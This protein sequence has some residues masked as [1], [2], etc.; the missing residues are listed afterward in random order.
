MDD[1]NKKGFS[2]LF[3]SLSQLI[4][5]A[6]E[7]KGR[8]TIQQEGEIDLGNIKDGMKAMYGFRL[9][10]LSGGIP[11]VET[12]G[13]VKNTPE[14]PKVAEERE[15]LTDIFD[16]ADLIKVYVEMPGVEA[17]DVSVKLSGD[18]LEISAKNALRNYRK[19]LLLPTAVVQ[20]SLSQQF[21]NGMLEIQLTKSEASS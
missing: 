4:D 15:P 16:E 20:D 3:D 11:T 9:G 17:E 7:L 14:G 8:E 13:N 1:K 19:E 10:T 5:M 12:F 2:S 18:I 6:S 21:K